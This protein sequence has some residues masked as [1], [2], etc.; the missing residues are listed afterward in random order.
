MSEHVRAAEQ[1]SAVGLERMG[2]EVL[3]VAQAL[4]RRVQSVEHRSA[5]AADRVGAEVSAHRQC[6]GSAG[7]STPTPIQAPG[8]GKARRRD[9]PHHRAPGRP[10]RQRRAPFGPGH[11]RC[12]R[13]SLPGHRRIGQR[14]ERSVGELADRIRQSEERTAPPAGGRPPE[15]RRTSCGGAGPGRATAGRRGVVL[16]R[17]RPASSPRRRRSRNPPF[18]CRPSRRRRPRSLL[19]R[20]R[21]RLTPSSVC[22]EPPPTCPEEST[23]TPQGAEKPAAAAFDLRGS[24]DLPEAFASQE[25]EEPAEPLAFDDPAFAASPFAAAR[26]AAGPAGIRG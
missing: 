12:R 20:R 26:R 11:R 14:H 17:F 3:E 18:P 2:R 21:C 5:A 15:D 16:G 8:A 1:R 10:D 19:R 9:R 6:G 13:T 23:T 24:A 4:N 25:A 22:C 7:W